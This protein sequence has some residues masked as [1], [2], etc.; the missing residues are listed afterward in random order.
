[1]QLSEWIAQKRAHT[2][3][4][5]QFDVRG[6]TPS[7]KDF[8]HAISTNKGPIAVIAELA[9]A[10]PEEGDLAAELDF[11]ALVSALDEASVSAIAIATDHIACRGALREVAEV[12]SRTTTPCIARDLVLFEEQVYASRLAE[13]DAALLEAQAVT[14]SELKKLLEIAASLHIAAPVEV[15]T[16]AEV[17]LAASCGA[18]QAVIPAFGAQGALDLSLANALLPKFPRL[19]AP[20]VRG[21]FARPADFATL[22]GRVDA[23]WLCG[24]L[25]RAEDKLAFLKPL[26]DAAE[27]G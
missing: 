23:I 3:R 16:E 19:L 22:R 2:P 27:N 10:T 26:I 4:L 15:R 25:M 21:P 7:I 11:A 8:T 6:I 5:T 14:P 18:R 17:A 12:A 20:I 1:M 24:P 13:A 9:R